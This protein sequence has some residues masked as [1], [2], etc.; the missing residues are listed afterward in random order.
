VCLIANLI[1]SIA[2]RT[3]YANSNSIGVGRDWALASISCRT[4]RIDS[5][6]IRTSRFSVLERSSY[7][8]S[9]CS[10]SAP[11]P[12]A[13]VD[14]HVYCPE[15]RRCNQQRKLLK[16]SKRIQAEMGEKQYTDPGNAGNTRNESD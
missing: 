7:L 14:R 2:T 8:S 6:L 3:W 9:G 1:R 10:P 15:N 11:I 4:W 5:E 12:A 16:M 13:K